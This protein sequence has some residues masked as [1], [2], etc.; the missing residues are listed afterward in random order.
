MN[1]VNQLVPGTF[2]ID[3]I[4]VT[5]SDRI[6]RYMMTVYSPQIEDTSLPVRIIAKSISYSSDWKKYSVQ[7]ND[8]SLTLMINDKRFDNVKLCPIS[9]EINFREDSRTNLQF[10][11]NG[12]YIISIYSDDV[13]TLLPLTT[14]SD[15]SYIDGSLLFR[16]DIEVEGAKNSF[17]ELSD[18]VDDLVVEISTYVKVDENGDSSITGDFVAHNFISGNVNLLDVASSLSTLLQDFNS[19]IQA[20][21]ELAAL[22]DS[23][24]NVVTNIL[25][26]MSNFVTKNPDGSIS[27]TDVKFNT[28]DDII[29]V[30]DVCN[31]VSDTVT[32]VNDITQ[33]LNQLE[34]EYNS[35]VTEVTDLKQTVATNSN[36]I[37]TLEETVTSLRNA[38]SELQNIKDI[39]FESFVSYDLEHNVSANDFKLDMQDVSWY[40][41]KDSSTGDQIQKTYTSDQSLYIVLNDIINRVGAIGHFMDDTDWEDYLTKIDN[42]LIWKDTIDSKIL[43]I[44]THIN[45]AGIHVTQGEK[46]FI[47]KLMDPDLMYVVKD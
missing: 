42:L 26:D 43:S 37:T 5:E 41:G 22:V 38:V 11:P 27:V 28:G 32:T 30:L 6:V 33:S 34:L 13:V 36:N 25:S 35:T 2:F 15:V 9:S 1:K 29:S 14:L 39:D 45:N 16:N 3:G 12:Y 24:R 17:K 46:D 21:N 10:Q 7:D 18:I 40:A 44:D 20:Y 47:Q 23:I 19:H 31:T 8:C 4:P